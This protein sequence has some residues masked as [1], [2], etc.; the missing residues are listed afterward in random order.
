[1]T[2]Y[3]SS[4][5]KMSAAGRLIAI[6]CLRFVVSDARRSLYASNYGGTVSHL[7]FEEK[8]GVYSVSLLAETHDCGYNPA[9]MELD[10]TK[11]TL[12]CLNEAY[13]SL[14]FQKKKIE[15]FDENP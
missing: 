14:A 1:M 10:K 2:S 12:L 15:R 4:S 7:S 11:S 3:R 9:W 5:V 13:V 6:L 8:A